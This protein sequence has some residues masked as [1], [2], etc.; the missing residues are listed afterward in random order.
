[1]TDD[2]RERWREQHRTKRIREQRWGPARSAAQSA[3]FWLCLALALAFGA[4][5]VFVA[6]GWGTLAFVFLYLALRLKG[7]RPFEGGGDASGVSAYVG[8]D[9]GGDSHHG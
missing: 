6:W 8:G 7:V 5:G 9:G 4:L 2:A 1:M 3:G